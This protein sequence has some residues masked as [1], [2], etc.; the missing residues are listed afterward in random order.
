MADVTLTVEAAFGSTML[1]GSPSWTDISAY[2]RAGSIT[3]GRSSVDGRFDT[4]TATL[5]LDNRTGRFTPGNTAGAYYPNVQIG[6]PV[7]ITAQPESSSTTYPLFYGSVRAWP[8]TFP[9]GNIDAT[10]TV[11][12]ADGFYNLNLEDIAGQSYVAQRTDQRI[13]A[14]LDD[15]S[16]PAGLRD[17]DA[18]IGTVQPTDVAQPN[19]GGEQ[20]A[21]DHMLDVAE[22]EAGALF[23]GPN[24]DVVF[25]N[26]VALSGV[27]PTV[28]Y[29]GTDD[30]SDITFAYD[31][32]VLFNDI[33]IA[34]EGGAQVT[35][36]NTTSVNAH[37][38][39]VLTRDVMPMGNDGEVLNVAE[40]LSGLFG[41]QRLR[42]TGL[43]FK[44]LKDATLLEE[45]LGFD[46]RQ[47]VTIQHAPPAG[48]SLD[49]D[50]AIEQIT[51]EF[52]PGDW[53]TTWA[54]VPLTTIET[55]SYWILGTSQLD[56]STR[57]A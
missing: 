10:V 14:V 46:L 38:R 8:P 48:D 19:D 26:R 16:W 54:V 11:P 15:L 4:G 55:Q 31:D 41:D 5:T 6:V 49:V 17:L 28:T 32:G 25:Q 39:R 37:G 40:W 27:T 44:P 56:V 2:V 1:D 45:L 36:V 12:L 57:L 42:I 34:R 22:A 13:T 3:R 30:Y 23:M 24:G 29:D 18:G 52:A 43:R 9:T 21:L 7:R 35:Y 50:C 53:T 51:H 47:S 20:P 33:R